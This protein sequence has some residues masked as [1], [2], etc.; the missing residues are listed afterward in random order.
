MKE[1]KLYL[2]ESLIQ[3]IDDNSNIGYAV[4]HYQSDNKNVY[5]YFIL[6][7]TNDPMVKGKVFKLPVDCEDGRYEYH[8]LPFNYSNEIWYYFIDDLNIELLK[9]LKF[10]DFDS[11]LSP[12]IKELYKFKW[13]HDF[14]LYNDNINFLKTI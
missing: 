10:I 14:V 9:L 1:D 4:V 12:L 2:L 6:V 13:V 7:N 5:D 11:E 8:N 3:I